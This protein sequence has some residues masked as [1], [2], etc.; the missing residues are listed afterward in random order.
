MSKLEAAL[1]YNPRSGRGRPKEELLDHALS[2]LR[3]AGMEVE[4]FATKA[5]GDATEIA[6]RASRDGFDRVLSWGGDG[7]LNEVAAGLVGTETV[8]GVVPGGTVN[9]FAREVGIPRNVE[10]SIE[11]LTGG[12]PRRI[13]VGMAGKRPFLLMTGIGLDAEVVYRLQA[14]FK[15]AFGA[16]AF[17]LDG[18]RLLATYPMT[19]LTIR[20]PG[21]EIVAT[22]L[23]AG[24]LR[25]FGPRYF[26]T[27]EARLE[28]P[29]LHVVVFKGRNRRDY[30]RY[31][32][33]VLSHRHLGFRD[34]EH[35][36][37]DSL[38]VSTEG[39]VRVQV[40]GEPAGYAPVRIGVRDRALTVMLP[41]SKHQGWNK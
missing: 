5:P 31:L 40:D 4:V 17:W 39:K 37:T 22:G 3:R 13:P 33:G 20:A 35:F 1:I 18:F 32:L 28:E 9:V 7:T 38:E 23:I 41:K 21:H 26:I 8:L 36:K 30:L 16:L 15:N 10:G 12:E 34:V 25:R 2:C 14:G 11:V 6:A 27:P 19:P 24:K 29:K